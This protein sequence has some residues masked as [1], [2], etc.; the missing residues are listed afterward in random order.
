MKR[1]VLLLLLVMAVAVAQNA[2][3]AE[4]SQPVVIP[5]A[6]RALYMAGKGIAVNPNDLTDFSLLKASAGRIRITDAEKELGV[7]H[8]DDKRYIMKNIQVG[9]G[10]FYAELYD[11]LQANTSAGKISLDRI[12]KPAGEVWAGVLSLEG[13]EYYAYITGFHRPIPVKEAVDRVEEF[14]KANPEN[15][16]CREVKQAAQNKIKEYCE[17]HPDDRKCKAVVAVYCA[18]HTD[19]AS[20]RA[21]LKEYCEK[22]PDTAVC[23]QEPE[24]KKVI[25]KKINTKIRNCY[26]NCV[27][28]CRTEDTGIT[29]ARF[30]CAV[31]CRRECT[32]QPEKVQQIKER[33]MERTRAEK[34]RMPELAR[35][36]EVAPVRTREVAQKGSNTSAGA[37]SGKE[38]N[39]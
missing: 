28:E 17:N 14:C 1:G 38:V 15:E 27:Q 18:K 23:T 30:S 6:V 39:A 22:N 31:K 11:S 37:G 8:I 20:C 16:R 12:D 25:G 35:P 2:P 3:A 9:N 24:V 4:T 32:Y 33:V 13:K 34:V 10:S 7:M 29:A 36:V 26:D 21:R 19:D 5:K